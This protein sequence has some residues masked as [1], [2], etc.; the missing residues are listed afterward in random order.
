MRQGGWII[1]LI[2]LLVS[3]RPDLSDDEI[4]RVFRY[5]ESADISTLDPAFARDQATIWAT[6]QLFNGLVQLTDELE[7]VP[8]IAHS[9]N[10]SSDGMTYTFLLKKDIRFHRNECIQ[11]YDSRFVTA[12]DFVYSFN[13]ILDPATASPGA[14]IF[15]QVTE[16][17]PFQAENDSTFII[18][19]K[20]PFP[21]FL[22]LLSMPYCFVVPQEA[23][24]IY[25]NDFRRNPVGT[26]P[27][28]LAW[29]K[30]GVKLVFSRNPDYF[31]WENGHQLPLMEAVS[32]TFLADKQA[33][34]LRFIQGKLDF[35]S[36]IDPSYKDELL[37]PEGTLNPAYSNQCYL[38]TGPY[39]NTEYL[40]ILM[41]SRENI[42]HSNPLS[43][44][45]VRKAVNLSFDRGKMIRYL[46]NNIGTPG[47]FGMIPPGMPGFDSS[48]I[49]YDY[50][51]REAKRLLREAG[52][53]E[54]SEPVGIT[55]STTPDYLDICK[56]I[57]H[58]LTESNI[59]MEIEVVSP[60]AMK[61]MKAL[62]KI[63]FFRA[64]WIA[65]YPDAENYLS[66]FYSPNFCPQGPNYTHFSFPDFDRL[67]E[68]SMGQTNDSL[69]YDSFRLMETLV[70]EQAPVVVLYYDKV[71]R[72]VRND[73]N[74]LGV[75]PMNLLT[76]KRVYKDH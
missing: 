64:S 11:N 49:Y 57:Q 36:G 20:K 5:N 70:M 67:F 33:A 54:D 65:D 28:R 23:I 69:R 76:L 7:V 32:I 9:W 17:K 46:R 6:N 74:D 1:L 35:L 39:L 4:K 8:C 26:G 63:P 59:R 24:A 3:C 53:P 40:G 41:D 55:L 44:V 71:L 19:L 56:F 18:R 47:N 73:V 61:E 34:F 62:A 50:N 21:P 27:F 38:I 58:Q 16:E 75:N 31:E 25:G 60:S 42:N 51:P 12:S 37:T 72:F 45:L 66:L 29:W 22:S 30:E 2:G 68:T 14:W 13:R 10:I 52:F 15:N 43:S 48:T